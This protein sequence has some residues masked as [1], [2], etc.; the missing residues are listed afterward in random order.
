MTTKEYATVQITIYHESNAYS[1][2]KGSEPD[3][4]T[5]V[6]LLARGFD[7]IDSHVISSNVY[8]GIF[9]ILEKKTNE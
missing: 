9:Y 3:A 1:N 4:K 7:I 8:G 2:F 5:L 6:D